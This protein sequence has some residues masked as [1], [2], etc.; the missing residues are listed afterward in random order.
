MCGASLHEKEEM[1]RR[2]EAFGLARL[3]LEVPSSEELWRIVKIIGATARSIARCIASRG[4]SESAI[5]ALDHLV[6]KAQIILAADNDPRM[7]ERRL[8]GV[9]DELSDLGFSLISSQ[10][11]R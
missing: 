3:A 2:L 11:V 7:V 1:I 4:N 6:Y 9:C 10:K 5:K 8:R